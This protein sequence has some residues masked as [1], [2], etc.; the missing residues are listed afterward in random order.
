VKWGK[1]KSAGLGAVRRFYFFSD[2]P[3]KGEPRLPDGRAR[4][5][6]AEPLTDI[7][8]VKEAHR[9]ESNLKT[10]L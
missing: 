3:N 7:A 9:L 10:A 8:G 1:E 2:W 6:A 4:K 5:P